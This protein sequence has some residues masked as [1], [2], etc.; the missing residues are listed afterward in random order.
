MVVFLGLE[1]MSVSVYVLAGINRKSGAAAEAALK[2][3]LLGAFASGFLLY[4]IA[5]VYGATAT[6]NLTQIAA[7]VRSL[8]LARSP[9]LLIG[10]GLVLVGFGF[11]VAAVAVP[12]G[13]PDGYAGSPTPVTGVLATAGGKPPPPSPPPASA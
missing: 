3:F 5:L 9:M 10:L 8:S 11:K 4:G 6:T 1:L 12:H 13:G 7:Q 2:Y